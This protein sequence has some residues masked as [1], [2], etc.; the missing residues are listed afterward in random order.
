MES[1][2]SSKVEVGRDPDE[3]QRT[4]GRGSRKGRG[5]VR[6]KTYSIVIAFNLLELGVDLRNCTG[7]HLWRSDVRK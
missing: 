4:K 6:E 7:A 5:G 3:E 1:G 2:D